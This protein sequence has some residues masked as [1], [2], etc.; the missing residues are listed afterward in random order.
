MSFIG[1]K[2]LQ[3]KTNW[4]TR[5]IQRKVNAVPYDQTQSFALLYCY[6]NTAKEEALNNWLELLKADQKDVH[7]LCIQGNKDLPLS[8]HPTLTLADMTAL[9]NIKNEVLD[10]FLERSYDYFIHLDF[11][12]NEV[13]EMIIR[14]TKAKCKIGFYSELH[15]KKYDLMIG[16][17]KSAGMVNFVTQITKY[18]KSI[19]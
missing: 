6:E 19:K 3:F 14:K 16:M 12:V 4:T 8:L 1:K 18:L 9:G 10:Q 17:N 2:I 5:N 15:Q 7:V 13:I 11:D